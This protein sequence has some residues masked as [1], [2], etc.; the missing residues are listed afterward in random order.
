MKLLVTGALGVIGRA[1][2]ERLSARADV[3]V[4][5]LARRAPDAGL[6]ESLRGAPNPVQWLR[7]DLRDAAATRAALAPHRDTTHL[8]Y[9]ALFE[10]P[11]LIRGWL[12]PDHVDVNAAMLASTLAAL[13]AAPIAQ[14]SLLQG[15]KAY[16]VHTRR[17]MRVPV[18][19]DDAV[20]DHAN[21]YF[22]QQDLLEERAARAGFAWTIFRP[23]VVLGVAVGSAMNPVAALGAYA[24]I[25]REL[26]LPLRH[27]GHPDLLTECTDARLVASAIEW[28]W[29]E[30][31]AHGEAINLTNGDVVVWRTFF[32]RL[33]EEFGMKL[34]DSPAERVAPLAQAMPGHA[35]LWRRI[36][37]RDSLRVADLDALIGLS[38]Q[39]ADILWAAA[40]P[41][42]VPMLVSTIKARRLGFADCID[43]EQCILEHLCAMRALRYLP[44]DVTSESRGGSASASSRQMLRSR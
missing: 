28:S 5:G 32:D 9:A 26:G 12:A 35:A 29:R 4:V 17:A 15:T 37:E 39:Y 3:Q 43:S 10:K 40:A 30:P 1:V 2:V 33:A 24:V 7:C 41:R 14:V 8:V 34:E 21:F 13:D 27:P 23:Q 44:G 38:W 16:G 22:A 20:R 18:R 11:E 19:E 6:A 25:Q 36:A 42:P 31:R